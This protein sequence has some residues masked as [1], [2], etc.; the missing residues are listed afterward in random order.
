VPPLNMIDLFRERQQAAAAVGRHGGAS[1]GMG[2]LIK[3]ILHEF[4]TS[5]DDV[6]GPTH[7]NIQSIRAK[8]V[9]AVLAV[10]AGHLTHPLA[11]CA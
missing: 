5:A 6:V 7:L 3:D 8:C 10:L 9:L 4:C 2:W 1:Y 11:A